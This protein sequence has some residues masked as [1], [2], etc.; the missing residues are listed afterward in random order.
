[1]VDAA[2]RVQAD[3]C[4][5]LLQAVHACRHSMHMPM[6]C[7]QQVP[8]TQIYLSLVGGIGEEVFDSNLGSSGTTPQVSMCSGVGIL[9]SRSICNINH[10]SD[11]AK[12]QHVTF[13]VN[14]QTVRRSGTV[15]AHMQR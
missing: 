5:A 3:S 8:V 15:A 1:M 9:T 2:A 4:L 12:L 6:Q 13:W 10:V 11:F 7:M 14:P